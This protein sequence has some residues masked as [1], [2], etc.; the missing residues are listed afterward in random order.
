M[1]ETR[2][3]GPDAL[4]RHHARYRWRRAGA[5]RPRPGKVTD[6]LERLAKDC[7]S[8]RVSLG[9]ILEALES[10][11]HGMLLLVLA[12]PAMIPITP[13]GVGVIFGI[14]IAFVAAQL[15]LRRRY[16]WLPQ[17]LRQRSVTCEDFKSIVER[18]LPHVARIERLLKPRLTLLTGS[19][20]ECLIGAAV[21]VLALLL[22]LPL[23]LTNIPLGLSIALLSLGL[24]QRDGLAVLIGSIAAIATGV[25]IV[26]FSW[27]AVAGLVALV[28]GL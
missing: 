15:I 16:V 1:S 4:K 25:F 17:A 21:M 10:R 19:I 9:D 22:A 14:P 28:T 20:G 6:L 2:D 24:I 26:T 5:E 3:L 11:S 8:E 13:P 7:T 27:T 12:L 18:S 23:P